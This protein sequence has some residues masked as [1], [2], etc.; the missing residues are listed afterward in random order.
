MTRTIR[1]ALLISALCFVSF[2]GAKAQTDATKAYP[3]KPVRIIVG[4]SPGGPTD[5]IA[6]IVAQKL[7]EAWGQQ[8]YVEN[9]AGRQQH[10]ECDGRQVCA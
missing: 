5:V 9:I 7:S 6:R 2:A 1:L 8:V 10:R 3:N 4:F